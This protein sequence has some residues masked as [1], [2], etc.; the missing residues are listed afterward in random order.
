MRVRTICMCLFTCISIPFFSNCCITPKVYCGNK[1]SD[2]EMIQI[3]GEKGWMNINGKNYLEAALLVKIDSQTV[4][5]YQKGW[6]KYVKATAGERTIE[7]RHY[8]GWD[9]KSNRPTIGISTPKGSIT[10]DYYKHYLLRFKADKGKKYLISFRSE[11]ANANIPDIYVLDATTNK[12]ISCQVELTT[13]N[14]LTKR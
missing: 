9:A 1:V 10:P 4:G 12:P 14:E 6:P 11:T 7:I 13:Q 2:S 8:R 3:A 5:S